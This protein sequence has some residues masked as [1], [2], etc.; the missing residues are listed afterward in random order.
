MIDSFRAFLAV[1]LFPKIK[2]AIH[3]I[4]NDLRTANGDIKWIDPAQAHL[5]LKFL[6]DINPK[7]AEIIQ[8]ALEPLK[9]FNPIKFNLTHLGT[10]PK[11]QQARIIW[12]EV[13]DEEKGIEKLT[14]WINQE[15]G[16]SGFAKEPRPYNPHITLGR[17]RSSK[18][19]ESLIEKVNNYPLRSEI[20]QTAH[21]V[22]L[23]KS[24]LSQTGPSYF[25]IK[26]FNLEGNTV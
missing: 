5:T 9:N 2:E 8:R 21:E 15:L 10:F 11:G 12:V 18:N 24:I 3:H 14:K 6:G 17:L 13:S 23:Y 25:P 22:T 19:I 20:T 1:D 7:Q 16:I 26:K 4:Q